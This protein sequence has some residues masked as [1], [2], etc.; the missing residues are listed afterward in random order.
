MVGMVTATSDA[1]PPWRVEEHAW[2]LAP[3]VRAVGRA[4][5]P[6]R[7]HHVG[8]DVPRLARR[9]RSRLVFCDGE[10]SNDVWVKSWEYHIISLPTFEPPTSSPAA[11][12][13]VRTL[14]EEGTRGWEAVGLTAMLDGGVV[15]LLKR[16]RN[17]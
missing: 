3:S 8:H 14:N 17:D 1:I 2:R 11:S 13:A 7:H 5:P 15:V 4:R 10:Q 9:A 12:P 6:W 16:P